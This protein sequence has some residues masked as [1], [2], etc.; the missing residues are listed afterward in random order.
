LIWRELKIEL[1][2]WK[3]VKQLND[4]HLIILSK[5]EVRNGRILMATHGRCERA[6]SGEPYNTFVYRFSKG[7]NIFQVRHQLTSKITKKTVLRFLLAVKNHNNNIINCI[8]LSAFQ[9]SYLEFSKIVMTKYS[10]LN[11]K[12]S[13]N[14]EYC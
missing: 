6:W 7:S 12:F 8:K 4:F 14:I 9:N 11:P 13:Q 3:K 2:F 5:F 10:A 1:K